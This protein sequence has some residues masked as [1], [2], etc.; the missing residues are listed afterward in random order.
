MR[1]D[2]T[3]LPDDVAYLD[4][5]GLPWEAV[6]DGSP[7]ILVHD[8]AVPAGY[9]QARVSV[10]IR[11]ESGYPHAQLDMAYFN[12]PL[13]RSNGVPIKAA[14]STQNIGGTAWQR[15]SRHRTAEN[16]WRV[17]EDCLGTHLMLVQHWLDREVR[18]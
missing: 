7:W 15:W 12:P 13:V 18:Q 6:K 9:M 4:S 3:P 2:F 8:F 16:P 10:A 14:D 1:R 5:L 11:I 17:G